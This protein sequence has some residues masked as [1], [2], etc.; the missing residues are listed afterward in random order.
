MV[1]FSSVPTDKVQQR[2]NQKNINMMYT[3]LSECLDNKNINKFNNL[4]RYYY[5]PDNAFEELRERYDDI[6]AG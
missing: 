5:L 6:I 1:P 4:W 2:H 3:R